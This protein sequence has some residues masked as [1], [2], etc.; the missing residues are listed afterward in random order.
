MTPY[1]L[2]KKA[3]EFGIAFHSAVIFRK[4]YLLDQMQRGI[5]WMEGGTDMPQVMF[6][7]AFDEIVA[8]NRALM[9]PTSTGLTDEMVEEA[10]NYPITSL[11]EFVRGKTRCP[12]HDDKNPSAFHGTRTNRLVCPVC[13]KT[14]SSL[15]IMMERD[16]MTFKDAVK[17]LANH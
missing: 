12:F 13:A 10:R 8:Y 9:R 14:W 3:E 4:R 16:G 6:F 17:L 7:E 1:T 2:R 5:D 11:F 15:D